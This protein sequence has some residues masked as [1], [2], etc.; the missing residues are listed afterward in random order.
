MSDPKQPPHGTGAEGDAPSVLDDGKT[1][2]REFVGTAVVGGTLLAAGFLSLSAT[3]QGGAKASSLEG[4]SVA[5]VPIKL[6]VNGQEH[7]LEVEPRVTLLD[8]LRENLGLTG[9]KKGCDLGQ[10]GACTVLVE[11]RRVNSCLTLAVMQQGKRITTIEGLSQGETLHPMQQSF[12]A[13][14]GFQCGYC[15]P[16]QIMSAVGFSREP[17]GQ[18]DADIREGMC[19]NICRCGAYPHIVAAVRDGR[20]K[21]A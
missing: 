4:P 19:G 6:Q 10:C 3:A 14:D 13:H 11:G 21:Q 5:P 15:T 12:L 8:A 7:A 2:R 1:T 18:T 16:G 17:W 20:G 9:S